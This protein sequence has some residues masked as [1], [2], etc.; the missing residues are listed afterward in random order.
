MKGTI[1]EQ[2]ISVLEK[3][4]PRNQAKIIRGVFKFWTADFHK[5]MKDKRE[6][7]Q[8]EYLPKIEALENTPFPDMEPL[9]D[10]TS[11][12]KMIEGARLLIK[13][14]GAPFAFD[15]VHTALHGY[16]EKCCKDTDLSLKGDEEVV[17]IFKLL[18]EKHPSF[19][20]KGKDQ[21]EI[22]KI[23]RACGVIL[24]AT[25]TLR[26]H[27]SPAHPNP[28]MDEVDASFGIGIALEVM[29][30]IAALVKL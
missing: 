8:R 29:K 3:A 27:W 17:A 14:Q 12:T 21:D 6:K 20:K 19:S 25:N 18:Q 15:K 26:N 30:F 16:L 2:F 10:A 28:L 24:D 9:T 4:S 5:G 7:I 13:E 1:K 23:L 11:V 22:K